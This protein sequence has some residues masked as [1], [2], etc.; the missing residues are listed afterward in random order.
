M[1]EN[2]ETLAE[3]VKS[4]LDRAP[5]ERAAWLAAA[6]PS[7]GMRAEVESL[8]GFQE[9]AGA[10][11]E[12]GALE[13]AAESLTEELP[14][15][16]SE[17]IGDYRILARIGSGGMGD[18]FLAE[19]VNLKRK[20]ALKLVRPGMASP[21][22]LRRFRS[23]EQILASLNHPN[24]AHLHGAGAASDAT[25]FFVMEHVEGVP[26][27]AY[28][29]AQNLSLS[30][31]LE[32]FRKVC[33]AVQYAHQHLVIH[34]DLKP[35]NILVTE[36]GEPKLLD[37]G[38][39]KLLDEGASLSAPRT[40]TVEPIMTPDYASPEQVRG[41][42]VTTA[43]DVYGLGV[44]LYEL[45][46]GE[47]PYHIKSRRPDEIARAITE[48]EPTRPS[49]AAL[50]RDSQI[51]SHDARSLRGDLD[52]IVLMAMRKEP[53]RRYQSVAQLSEDIR[54]HL[55]AQP[56]SAQ[57]DTVR[58]RTSKFVRRHK[59]SV[60]A[61]LLV[62]GSLIAGIVA[63]AIEARRANEQRQNAEER[64]NDVRRLA[65]SLMFEIHDAVKDLQGST[66]TRRL[67]VTRALEYLDGLARKKTENPSLQREL[68]T[69]YEKIGDIQG[70]PYS[71][72]LGDT[73]GALTSYRKAARIRERLGQKEATTET[74]MELGRTYRGLGDILEVK[75]DTAQTIREYRRSLEIFAQLAAIDPA[76]LAVQ[77]ELARADETLADGLNRTPHA[78]AERLTNYEKALAIRE[79][80]LRHDGGSTK[81]RRSVA[82][83]LMKVGGASDPHRP[84]AGASI[85]RGV[86]MLESLATA[87]PN[88]SRARREVGWGYYQL[89]NTLGAG[90]DPAGALESRRKAFVIREKFAADD[91]QNAQAQFD[92][93]VSHADL[94][95]SFT[96]NG[97]P[98]QAVAHG[99]EGFEIF[100]ALAAADPSNAIYARNVALCAEKLGD[101]FARSGAEADASFAQRSSAWSEA[102]DWYIKARDIFSNLRTR[103]TLAPA[104]VDQPQRFAQRAAACDRALAQLPLPAN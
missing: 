99:R 65:N 82:L 45:L 89:G 6:C 25:P 90:D 58:Y 47:R 32:L 66:P 33:A 5:S 79:G 74:Q 20:V 76:N 102:R 78:D 70:N 3:L 84:E 42:N 11:I 14:P 21:D 96:A 27:D 26:I 92:L 29:R 16:L 30:D 22:L 13:I 41:E 87:D 73:E 71:A 15:E 23:E 104:D 69:A 68:A 86:A 59:V 103:G 9:Q 49:M 62:A 61:A 85:R 19:D 94:A 88:N 83:S 67:I 51:T 98:A 57:K 40:V 7:A 8:L 36:N 97:D 55:A 60:L 54:R 100:T 93:A 17:R 44:L 37:F 53:E 4:A 56:V 1:P 24:I 75:G 50:R 2:P 10:F 31:R 72:N 12:R 35:S 43:S 18:V 48:Q 38:I 39:A 34:R 77:D 63:T 81:L 46:T 28:C 95:E 101:A 64:F 80:L 91:P 52:N